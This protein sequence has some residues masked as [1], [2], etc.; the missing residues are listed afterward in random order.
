MI[1]WLICWVSSWRGFFPR[2]SSSPSAELL[3]VL[4]LISLISNTRVETGKVTSPFGTEIVG[5]KVTI[6]GVTDPATIE[7]KYDDIEAI[8]KKSKVKFEIH[9]SRY[10]TGRF[11]SYSVEV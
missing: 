6:G 7:R 11:K 1:T 9:E 8:L 5:F 10:P 3:R 4:R 2:S